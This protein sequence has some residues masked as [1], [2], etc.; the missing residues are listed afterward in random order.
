MRD[1]RGFT[2]V[3]MIIVIAIFGILSAIAT[4]Y[5]RDWLD[6]YAVE[7]QTQQMYADLMTARV[8]AMQRNRIFFVTVAAN[9]YAIYEDTYSGLT[10]TITPDGDG[11]LQQG[12]NQDRLVTQTTTKYSLNCTE[13]YVAGAGNFIFTQNGLVSW[14]STTNSVIVWASSTA[15]PVT[16]CISLTTTRILMGKM[17]GTNCIAK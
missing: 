17:N 13:P 5:A 7:G 3:E 9:Q 6:R 4:I 16:D 10:S 14:A 12:S 8:G 11:S 15:S 1:E 2:L